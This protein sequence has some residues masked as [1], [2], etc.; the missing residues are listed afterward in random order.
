MLSTNEEAHVTPD[1]RRCTAC[2]QALD[3]KMLSPICADTLHARFAA[4]VRRTPDAIAVTDGGLNLTYA[5]LDLRSDALS[6]RLR[7]AGAQPREAVGVFLTRSIDLIATLLGVL[8]TGAFYVPL[9]PANP[10]SRL[11]FIAQDAGLNIVLTNTA[12]MNRTPCSCRAL[13]VDTA[14]LVADEAAAP[15]IGTNDLAYVIYTSGSTGV[16]KGV[17]IE[18]GS[19]VRLFDCTE[20]WFHFCARDVWTLFHSFAFDFSVWE[21]WGALL[22][23]GRLVIVP[24]GVARQPDAYLRLLSREGVT[25]LNQTPSAFAQLDRVD[26]AEA[27]SYPLVLRLVIFGG[28]GLDPRRLRCWYARRG[29]SATLVNMYGITETTVHVT[30]KVISPEIAGM[31]DPGLPIGQ[32][33]PD[34][35]IFLFDEDGNDVAP[36][37]VGEIYVSGPG[38]ARGYLARQ[39]LTN[40]RFVPHPREPSLRLYRTGDLGCLCSNGEYMYHGRVDDQVKIRGFRIELGEIEAALRALPDVREAAVSVQQWGADGNDQLVAYVVTEN[41][42]T[43]ANLR[44]A[45]S[46]TLPE[47]M[48][49]QAVMPIEMLPLTINGKLDRTRLP[50]LPRT[51]LADLM[52]V[53]VP[54][55]SVEDRLAHVWALTLGLDSVSLDTNLFDLGATSY[56]LAAVHVALRQEGI[57]IPILA[58]F[59]H[60]RICDLVNFLSGSKPNTVALGRT[61]ALRQREALSAIRTSHGKRT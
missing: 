18:H 19:V 53:K 25:V 12:L 21:I 16:P 54:A 29:T 11:D 49:P 24:E 61:S 26:E 34:L 35:R 31:A 60:P 40:Q 48:L 57:D 42:P 37:A 27:S 43:L 6:C 55:A 32:P 58:L 8:K 20:R 15:A 59:E 45:L 13:N 9:D 7:A 41:A 50:E 33:I 47:H 30:Y 22:Y 1:F 14:H 46:R 56:H 28:E 39:E 10:D 44:E 23:G 17:S 51:R 4:Q 38:L 36:G 52:P 5:E 3:T 2:N